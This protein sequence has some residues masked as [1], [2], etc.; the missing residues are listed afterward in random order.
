VHFAGSLLLNAVLVFTTF[1]A[2]ICASAW[3]E[4]A[5]VQPGGDKSGLGGFA[6]LL[7]FMAMRWL[8]VAVLLWGGVMRDAFDFLPGGRWS[9]FGILLAAHLALGGLCYWGFTAIT[10]G[11]QV[12]NMAPQR[13]T[14][15]VGLLI[16][17]TVLALA[18]WAV[19]RE[20]FSRNQ[21]VALAL[22]LALVLLQGFTY[23][24]KARDMRASDLRLKAMKEQSP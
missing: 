6:M 23:R 4:M 19:N 9:Q 13:W 18:A 16:P 12:D 17:V 11:L 10:N 14:W 3:G 5:G 22:L 21:P 8:G 2:I 1:C 15:V 24:S 7:M 20:F